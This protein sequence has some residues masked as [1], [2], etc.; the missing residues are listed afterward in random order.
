MAARERQFGL[1]RFLVRRLLQ[2]VPVVIAIVL[3]NFLLIHAAPGDP[4]MAL[5][6]GMETTPEYLAQVRREF[7][8]DQPL[9]VQLGTYMAHAARLDLGYSFHF[10][11]PVFRL[12]MS[13]MPATL[14]LMGS[15]LVISSLTGIALGALA[16]RRPFGFG[17]TLATVVALAGYSMPVFWLGQLML[18]VFALDLGWLP[19]QGMV[20][21]RLPRAGWGRAM[22]TAQHL[23]LPAA[24][25]GI[26]HLT[27]VYRL[28]R[29]K[30]IDSLS[31]DY[32][33]TARAKGVPE[34]GVLLRHALPNALSPVITVIG[35]NLGFMLAGSVF[36]E[37]VFG[38]PGMGRL[39]FEAV[40][41]RDRPLLLGLFI[42][43]SV[44]VVIG[45]ILT[46]LAHA[47][48]DPRT[49]L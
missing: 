13:R 40:G 16:S 41:V 24:T 7:G 49:A 23:V 8:L 3:I 31:Q 9:L 11:V 39:M 5:I 17:D 36:V 21:L 2:M 30:M 22:D 34:K 42:V 1:A 37:T 18:L 10:R 14:L 46:D 35:Y 44:F 38:W 20:S 12:I 32:I 47:F 15:A 25:Y 29:V 6:G 19:V 45:N 27:L 33:T 4:A 26:Y 28:T 48:L 43:V